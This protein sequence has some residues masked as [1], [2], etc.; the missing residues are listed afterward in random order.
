MFCIRVSVT[1]FEDQRCW[2]DEM[3][4]QE[5]GGAMARNQGTGEEISKFEVLDSDI[6]AA[7]LQVPNS[8]DNLSNVKLA[9]TESGR[10]IQKSI[11]SVVDNSEAGLIQNGQSHVVLGGSEGLVEIPIGQQSDSSKYSTES[12]EVQAPLLDKET[13]LFKVR[14]KYLRSCRNI[15]AHSLRSKVDKIQLWATPYVAPIPSKQKRSKS[16]SSKTRSLCEKHDSSFSRSHQVEEGEEIQAIVETSKA[17]EIRFKGGEEAVSKRLRDSFVECQGFRRKEKI[18]AAR[19]L[20]AKVKPNVGFFQETKLEQVNE[21]FSRKLWGNLNRCVVFS[22]AIRSAGGLISTWDP[23]FFNVS[24][25]IINRRFIGLVGTLR[26]GNHSIGFVNVYG[27]STD[28]EKKEFFEELSKLIM[29][30]NIAWV[31]GGDFNSYLNPEEK[32]GFSFN[33]FSMRVFKEFVGNMLGIDLPLCGGAFT[34]CNNRD[35]PTFVRLDLFIVT[36]NVILKFPNISQVLLTKALS[37]HNDILIHSAT[38]NWGLKPFKFFDYW[39]RKEGFDDL[40]TSVF[41]KL[42]SDGNSRGIGG[43]LR[44]SKKAIKTW[45]KSQ[46][47]DRKVSIYNLKANINELEVKIQTSALPPSTMN[48][49]VGNRSLSNP[50]LI[51]EAIKNHF[52]LEYNNGSALEVET[53]NLPFTK[54]RPEQAGQLESIAENDSLWKKVIQS[55]HKR[56]DL[57]LFPPPLSRQSSWVWKGIM[58]SSFADDTFGNIFQNNLSLRVG[59]SR[60]IHFWLDTWLCEQPLSTKFPHIFA[61]AINKVGV[62]TEFG[63]RRLNNWSWKIPLRRCLFDWEVP[64]WNELL[65]LLAKFHSSGLGRDWLQWIGSSDGLYSIKKMKAQLSLVPTSVVNWKK[66]V[67]IGLAPPKVEAFM[68]LILHERVPVKVEL[69]K[70]GVSL[71]ADDSCPLCNQARETVEHLFFTCSVSWQLWTS[72]ASCWGVS[73]VLHRNPLKLLID[74]PYLC[75]KFSRDI[76]WLLIPFA[77][78]WS[79]WLQMNEIIFHGKPRDLVQLVF[80]TKMRAAW[81]WKA[82]KTDLHIHLDSIISDPSL[83]SSFGVASSLSPAKC[84]WIPLRLGFLKF[85]VDGACSHEGKCG[86]GG[87]LRDANGSKLMEFSLSIGFGSPLLAEILEIKLAVECFVNSPWVNRSRLVVE[88]DSKTVV[89]WVLDPSLSSPLFS[90]L[91]QGISFFFT[92][93]RWSIPHIRRVQNVHADTLAKAGID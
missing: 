13:G 43:L 17:L 88:S 12:S 35:P 85:N 25:R 11:P 39:L 34:W 36:A 83:A 21:N 38:L 33:S 58:K 67:W 44:E 46:C 40:M 16:N 37:D 73:L 15:S 74:W 78:V 86:V 52:S 68:W 51:K 53:M 80:N 62:I 5:N 82:I 77:V 93:G 72:L 3:G 61:L 50:R 60:F 69:L 30:Y 55:K 27:P 90:K 9:N 54:L 56:G 28:S 57:A 32:L 41:S 18:K 63:V 23:D 64:S 19:D 42:S 20:L 65:T 14:P 66:V 47:Q 75:S 26:D 2:I 10:R 4:T 49:V 8:F 76:M 92:N 59:D 1:T 24:D 31:V 91:V 87:V 29:K 89:D 70:R 81:W 7:E 6:K 45:A 84:V 48:Q 79:I 22:P 71:V